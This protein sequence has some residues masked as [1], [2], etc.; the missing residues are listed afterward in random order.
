MSD[1]STDL[2]TGREPGPRRRGEGLL[3]AMR[4]GIMAM[5][6]VALAALYSRYHLSDDQK[7]FLRYIEVDVKALSQAR[8]PIED[9]MKDLFS[10]NPLSDR[11][12]RG[13][14]VDEVI[15]GLVRLRR[16]A[17]A[18]LSQPRIPQVRV[19][20]QEYLGVID[21][22]IGGCRAAVRAIDAR[23]A[24]EAPRSI[25]AS[26]AR[27]NEAFAQAAERQQAWREHVRAA[28]VALQLK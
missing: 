4:L 26:E 14:L 6:S 24:P 18:P 16:L 20:G 1:E 28:G 9:R 13:A 8:G 15:P 7:D 22:L 27:I 2:W 23:E 21:G 19:L 5:L 11:Q 25:E 12:M 10:A 17:A 3:W